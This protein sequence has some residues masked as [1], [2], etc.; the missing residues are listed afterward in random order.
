[1]GLF[2]KKKSKQ[3]AAI[4]Q[5]GPPPYTPSPTVQN[6]Y[7]PPSPTNKQ[8]INSDTRG[9]PDGWIS[10][11][12]P[13]SQRFFYVYTPNGLRQWEHPSDRSIQ[14]SNYTQQQPYGQ[15]AQQ[16]YYPQQ[17]VQQ[18]YGQPY[19]Q[20]YQ[21]Y[22]QQPQYVVQQQHQGTSSNGMGMAQTAAVGVGAGLLGFV[23]ADAIFDDGGF[24]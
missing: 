4:P 14:Q 22:G 18:P 15:Y 23:V 16:P 11:Y 1:M 10:Q 21:Q 17:Y 19:G 12:D 24:F 5:D 2:S 7:N 13:T 6:Q 20:P 3:S 8:P 9:L